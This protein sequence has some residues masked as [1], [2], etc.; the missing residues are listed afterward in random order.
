MESSQHNRKYGGIREKREKAG[1]MQKRGWG[2]IARLAF[3]QQCFCK[4]LDSTVKLKLLKRMNIR[5]L[6]HMLILTSFLFDFMKIWFER[7]IKLFLPALIL[8][9]HTKNWLLTTR[10]THFCGEHH[11][12][13][14]SSRNILPK[15]NAL[16]KRNTI[17]TGFI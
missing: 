7:D 10:A 3:N 5:F 11:V 8:T 1:W 14:L 9:N 6:L 12:L 13:E 2:Q 16:A 4:C 15:S 17:L